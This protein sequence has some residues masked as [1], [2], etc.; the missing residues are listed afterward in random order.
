MFGL[1]NNQSCNHRWC[2]CVFEILHKIK[3]VSEILRKI[4]FISRQTNNGKYGTHVT[5]S[6]LLNAACFLN[7]RQYFRD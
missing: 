1:S 6:V 4:K 5:N 7:I 3:C 2:V